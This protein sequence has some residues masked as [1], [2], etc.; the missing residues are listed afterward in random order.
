MLMSWGPLEFKVIGLNTHEYDQ[1]TSSAFA[2]KEVPGIRPPREFVGEDDEELYVRGRV[3]PRKL[4]GKSDLDLLEALRRPGVAQALVRGTGEA[5]GWFV[6]ERLV[7]THRY[8]DP[9]GLGQLIE[10]E[11]TFVR[12][13][14]PYPDDY[15]G[16][17]FSALGG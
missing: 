17:I 11:A 4:P 1:L 9:G 6:M 2:K 7:R 8:L 16:L 5:L 13:P 3:F 15:I 12:V 14:V 10:F